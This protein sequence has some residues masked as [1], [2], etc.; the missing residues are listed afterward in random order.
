MANPTFA[1][2]IK[3]SASILCPSR[4]EHLLSDHIIT[5]FGRSITITAHDMFL[6][7]LSILI[8]AFFWVAMYFARRRVVVLKH[9][10]AV[11]QISLELARIANSLERIANRPADRIIAAATRRR[12]SP[13]P[14]P[15]P[16]LQRESKG[17]SYSIFG[18]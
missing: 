17:I 2:R 11:D 10:S 4:E 18:R 15:L 13:E 1:N 7:G 6:A 3:N 9:S 16:P 12:Q 5:I 8:G 14:Q